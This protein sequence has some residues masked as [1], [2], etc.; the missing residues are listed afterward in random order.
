M[1][2][3]DHPP[4]T[5]ARVANPSELSGDLGRLYEYVCRHFLA[6]ISAQAEYNSNT[7]QFDVNGV[8]FEEESSVITQDGFLSLITWKRS[9][10]VKNFPNVP[11]DGVYKILATSNDVR[12][13][14]PPDYV[15]ESELIKLM[16]KNGIG[17]DASMPV[18]IKNICDRVYVKVKY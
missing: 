5:P 18:H 11:K 7:I 17:T 10:Y 16:E 9:N 12:L 2:K 13:T 14:Q 1:D 3:G 6:S 4:I 15:T 8:I